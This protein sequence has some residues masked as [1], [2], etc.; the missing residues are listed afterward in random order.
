MEDVHRLVAGYTEDGSALLDQCRCRFRPFAPGVEV[1]D[2]W[3]A[4]T[5]PIDLAN[6]SYDGANP[7]LMPLKGQVVARVVRFLPVSSELKGEENAVLGGAGGIEFSGSLHRTKTLD[8][9]VVRRGEIWLVTEAEETCL[10][11][12]DA[13]VLD[14]GFHSWENRTNSPAEILS[15]MIGA[16]GSRSLSPGALDGGTP[17]NGARCVVLGSDGQGQ[18]AILV[19]ADL[20]ARIDVDDFTSVLPYW[21]ESSSPPSD[22]APPTQGDLVAPGDV[23]SS[24]WR[25]EV[26]PGNN[27][28]MRQHPSL[29]FITVVEGE[30]SYLTDNGEVALN[31]GDVLVQSGNSHRWRNA[32]SVGAAIVVVHVGAWILDNEGV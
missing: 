16:S 12:G 11:E 27:P 25:V 21:N 10:A 14:G 15:V 26:Q 18:A 1:C 6:P 5:S 17:G 9:V 20:A 31:Q 30:L 13:V 23:G 3:Q 22:N 4:A 32:G 28:T 2:I 7:I 24:F 19:D 29:D 8:Y